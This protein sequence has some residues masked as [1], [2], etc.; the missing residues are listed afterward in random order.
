MFL[1]EAQCLVH[2]D[3]CQ[4]DARVS[5]GGVNLLEDRCP[6]AGELRVGPPIAPGL[7]IAV[8]NLNHLHWQFPCDLGKLGH[9]PRCNRHP[10][11]IPAA[12][13]IQRT[14]VRPGAVGGGN[15]GEQ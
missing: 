4:P 8:I 1:F 14:A 3:R 6:A 9:V 13:A 12:P 10:L 11:V 7:L 5:A 2:E 15:L